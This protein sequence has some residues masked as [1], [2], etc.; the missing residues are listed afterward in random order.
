MKDIIRMNQLAGILTEGQARK[1]IQVLN[2]NKE[3]KDVFVEYP[4][5]D[6][7]GEIEDGKVSFLLIDE[8]ILDQYEE[9]FYDLGGDEDI[10]EYL[11]RNHFFTKLY[12]TIGGTFNID[13]DA[14]GITVDLNDLK[15]KFGQYITNLDKI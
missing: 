4:S 9:G 11:G 12:K 3:I 10:M 6:Y 15:S 2:E 13:P 8:D 1:M 14:V 5:G 7:S